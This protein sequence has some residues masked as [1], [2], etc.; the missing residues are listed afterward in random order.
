M[1]SIVF[2]FFIKTI[3]KKIKQIDIKK[4]FTFH[5]IGLHS[6]NRNS[7]QI[8]GHNTALYSRHIHNH[9]VALQTLLP[10][11]NCLQLTVDRPENT[12]NICIFNLR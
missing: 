2:L 12:K 9:S 7:N 4:V 1:F 11:L 3:D 8:C 6:P 5:Q 10:L